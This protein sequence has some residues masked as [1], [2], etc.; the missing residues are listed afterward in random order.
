MINIYNLFHNTAE[1]FPDNRSVIYHDRIYTFREVDGMICALANKLYDA[2]VRPKTTVG[3]LMYNGIDFFCLFYAVHKLGA[4]LM[5]LNWRLTLE[6]ILEHIQKSEC[7]TLIYDSE[8]AERIAGLKCDLPADMIYVSNGDCEALQIAPMYEQ[9]DPNWEFDNGVLPNDPAQYL[10]T[11]GT[12]SNSKIAMASQEKM[13]M[14]VLLPRLYNTLTYSKDDNFLTF[15][16]M[17]H[18]GGVGIYLPVSAAGGCLTMMDRM[19]VEA[20]LQAIEKYKVTRLLLLPPSLCYRIKENPQLQKYDTSSVKLVMLSGGGS[21]ANLARDV[22]DTFKNT[23]ISTSYG[24]TE[25][26]A[27]TMHEYTREQYEQ[28][29]N[30]A[31]SIGRRSPFSHIKLID[32]DGNQ[33]GVNEVG[34]CYAKAYGMLDGYLGR[35][36]PFV[37]GWFPTGDFLSYD[38]NGLYY[39][40]DRKNFVVKSGGELVIPSEV[41]G[42]LLKNDKVQKAAVFGLND[43]DYGEKVTAAVVLNPGETATEDELKDFVKSH[44]ASYKKPKTIFFLDDLMYTTVGKVDKRALQKFCQELDEQK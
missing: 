6:N 17:F 26:A 13:M 20:I 23:N 43:K 14:R 40:K 3:L 44:I 5:P 8:W 21:S 27:E 16:P 10:L 42:A 9:G 1:S 15:N 35:P 29:P 32:E 12:S 4:V 19:D 2:G 7:Q 33:V 37:D 28:N 41:E 36:S 34:E 38:E 24:A 11:G 18:Q 31:V 39:F 25:N 22:F 30:I